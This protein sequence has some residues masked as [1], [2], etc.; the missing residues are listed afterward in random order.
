MVDL[1]FALKE[2]VSFFSKVFRVRAVLP[3]HGNVD[4][5]WGKLLLV[6]VVLA[7]GTVPFSQGD[8]RA[9]E[10]LIISAPFM[11]MKYDYVPDMVY[12]LYLAPGQPLE[13][14]FEPGE[15]I[16]TI[17]FSDN[18]ESWKMLIVSDGSQERTR[19]HL[20][21]SSCCSKY[22][23]RPMTV[24]TSLRKYMLELQCSGEASLGSVSWTYPGKE[25]DTADKQS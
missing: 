19:Y 22:E 18:S 11:E 25:Y 4:T 16:E 24:I 17:D 3:Q 2:R 8:I 14:M 7:T 12:D 1:I 9:E 23:T 20:L 5:E 10:P 6:P 21:V 15:V 13:I